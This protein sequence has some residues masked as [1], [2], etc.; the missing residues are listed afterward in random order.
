MVERVKCPIC[1]GEACLSNGFDSLHVFYTCETC[2]RFEIDTLYL[3]DLPRKFHNHQ[4]LSSYLYYNGKLDNPM[5]QNEKSFFNFIGDNKNFEKVKKNNYW[6]FH[7]TQE[8]IDSWFP[9]S[10][11]EKVDMILLGFWKRTDYLGQ[12]LN[13]TEA[14][15]YSALFINRFSEIGIPKS[16]SACKTQV[17]FI[18][19]YLNQQDYV[20]YTPG[21]NLMLKPTALQRIDEL[22]KNSTKNSK[23][24][25]V[26]MSFDDDMKKIRESIRKAILAAGYNPRIMDEIEHNHQIVPEMLYEIRQSRFVV[27]DFTKRNNGAYYEA[28]YALGLGKEVIQ[29]CRKEAFA[30]DGHFDVKQVNTILWEKEDDLIEALVKR[31]KATI[32]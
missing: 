16:D 2:G 9:K 29:L 13:F 26:A 20:E 28:G 30:K 7:V 18:T 10:F 3:D 21:N 27:A 12:A 25:F 6:C 11:A 5:P 32:E 31:I 24:V 1:G 19:N 17:L 15:L 4:F 8:V 23:T 22:Q 14:E